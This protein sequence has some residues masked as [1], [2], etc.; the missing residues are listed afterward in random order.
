M[1]KYISKRV[2][3]EAYKIEGVSPYVE[4]FEARFSI[5]YSNEDDKL[6]LMTLLP[7]QCGGTP[8]RLATT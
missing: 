5:N 7:S 8:R 1:G 6:F 2:E 4:G 3:V